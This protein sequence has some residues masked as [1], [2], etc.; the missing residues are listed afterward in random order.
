MATFKDRGIVLRETAVGESDKLVTLL[1]KERG[2]LTVSA[3]G[4]RKPKSKTAAATQMFAYCDY[5]LFDG[6]GFYALAQAEVI[7]SFYEVRSHFD[8]YC[9]GSYFLEMA[10]RMLL[11]E[12]PVQEPLLLILRGLQALARGVPSAGL[13]G[14]IFTY[15]FL[16]LEGYAP[17]V[18][19]C[20][21]CGGEMEGEKL[22]FTGEGLCCAGCAKDVQ[23]RKI[24][25]TEQDAKSLREVLAQDA[26]AL[27]RMDVPEPLRVT[28]EQTSRLFRETNVEF[29]FKSL[30]MM[31]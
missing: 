31:E 15:K 26:G 2:K 25:L 18:D 21:V 8:A 22:F 19:V 23:T 9:Q 13:V 11:K 27:F 12:M 20:A 3:R 24:R 1:L 28:L 10:D 6:N 14:A 30:A 5:V 4:A 17:S 16:Q 29:P 7:E